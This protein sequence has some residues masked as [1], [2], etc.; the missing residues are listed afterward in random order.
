MK[1]YKTD[2]LA[3]A[4]DTIVV[5]I[6]SSEDFLP[7]LLDY[8]SKTI[9]L[10]NDFIEP[11]WWKVSRA[12]YTFGK[13]TKAK[14]KL[15]YQ[16]IGNLDDPRQGESSWFSTLNCQLVKYKLDSYVSTYHPVDEDGNAID[17]STY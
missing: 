6:V 12:K 14:C 17:F 11:D 10:Y 8:Q 5:K 9:V 16:I 15:Y 13:Y 1:V 7:G 3:L 4:P 2:N